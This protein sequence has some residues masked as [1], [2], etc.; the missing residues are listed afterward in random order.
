MPQLALQV[1]SQQPVVCS[2]A[3]QRCLKW[4]RQQLLVSQP[5]LHALV[6]QQSP[7]VLCPNQRL[8]KPSFGQPSSQP[9]G[10]QPVG[11]QPVGPQPLG[12]HALPGSPQPGSTVTGTMRARLM[13]T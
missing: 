13:Q 3:K 4:L 12:P 8:P 9:L 2:E 5:V 7:P 11:P 1:S 6:S 10:P